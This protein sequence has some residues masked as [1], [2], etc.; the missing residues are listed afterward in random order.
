MKLSFLGGAG[1]VTGSKYLLE[2]SGRRLL[3][4]CGLFQ[5]LK[6]LRLQNWE[7]FPIDPASIDA[8]IL[9]HAHI[10]HSGYLPKLVQ[11]GFRGPVYCTAATRDLCRILLLDSAMLM[12]EE[13]GFANRHHFSKHDPALPLYTKE[14]AEKCL[15]QFTALPFHE[16]KD[17]AGFTVQLGL[18]G[19]IL[20]AANLRVR[21]PSGVSIS[22]SGDVGRPDDPIMLPPEPLL[23]ADYYVVES[24]YGERTH[25][26]DESQK[27]AQIIA[28][29]VA[30]HG[31]IL[32]PSFAVGR[33]Q[34]LLYAIAEL[35]RLQRIPSV[36]VYL[37]SP[38]ATNV[39]DLYRNFIGEHHLSR[40][41]CGHICSG[42]G[43][44]RNVEESRAVAAKS[45]P[46]IVVS[47]SGMLTGGRVLHHLKEM[48]PHPE[49]TIVIPGYQAAGTRGA[50]IL[51]GAS[52]VKVHGGFVQIR[53]RVEYL[54]SF[55][56]HADG[57]EI[58]AWL[59]KSP[60]PRECFITHG[61]PGASDALRTRLTTLLGYDCHIPVL[62]ESV[63]LAKRD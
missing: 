57:A 30:G 58:T 48:A 49:N 60:A 15:A 54:E 35:K 1:T 18:A 43:F 41:E 45:A 17:V 52:E 61:E 24:T 46:R 21:A 51:S 13:A 2:E 9:T 14:D 20:G 63:E 27:L 40:E 44:V 11:A 16:S 55:S 26:E 7:P 28:E 31:S 25:H 62:G 32:I 19:H 29:T 4:D 47:A 39:T 3:V 34:H 38:M 42:V 8:V 56:A 6:A 50:Q 37:D 10:D 53:C 12:E 33:A 36:P 59:Q 23:P 5:G 22:F